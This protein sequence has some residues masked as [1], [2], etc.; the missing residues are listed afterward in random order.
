MSIGVGWNKRGYSTKLD[1]QGTRERLE[2]YVKE[3]GCVPRDRAM[4]DVIQERHTGS[5]QM[6]AGQVG[7]LV[8]YSRK[9]VILTS[10]ILN[11]EYY[12]TT[13]DNMNAFTSG[14]WKEVNQK[15]REP[16]KS[17]LAGLIKKG[18]SKLIDD[19]ELE[20]IRVESREIREAAVSA[21]AHGYKEKEKKSYEQ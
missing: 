14:N 3:R 8:K 18:R 20:R 10:F 21:R 1:Y 12:L 15:A 2:E 11:G 19:D 6:N 17:F 5:Y 16:K 13:V 7:Q 4:R 9:R